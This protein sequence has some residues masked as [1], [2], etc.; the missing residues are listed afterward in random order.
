MPHPLQE[1]TLYSP[2]LTKTVHR[3]LIVVIYMNVDNHAF[4]CT[5]LTATLSN[6]SG[7]VLN[8][9]LAFSRGVRH[10]QETL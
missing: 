7:S 8:T 6:I 1:G 2:L 10:P 9:S 4:S 5:L 3:T